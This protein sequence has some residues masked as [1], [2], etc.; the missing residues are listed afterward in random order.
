MLINI[1]FVGVEF[2]TALYSDIPEHLH[3]F[4]YLFF[5]LDGKTTMV[6]WMWFSQIL[7]ILAVLLILPPKNRQKEGLLMVG[8]CAVIV[9][10]WIEKGLGMVVGGF[11]PSVQASVVEYWPTLPEFLI[12]IGVYALGAAILT[13]LYRI[14]TAERELKSG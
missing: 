13:V 1:F 6:P 12:G 4:Q 2:F 10:I 9:A 14:A 3:H 8:C 7:G 11:V 5:G